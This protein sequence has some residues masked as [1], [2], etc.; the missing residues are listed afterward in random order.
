[1]V[2]DTAADAQK[3]TS[4]RSNQVQQVSTE[5]KSPPLYALAS[6]P[7]WKYFRSVANWQYAQESSPRATR[8]CSAP[9]RAP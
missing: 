7:K 3:H 4:R 8:A 1:M 2:Q 9:R 5:I 6:T